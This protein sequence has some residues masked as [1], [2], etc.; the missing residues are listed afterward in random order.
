MPVIL[1]A[2]K[3]YAIVD[4][5]RNIVERSYGNPSDLQ[6]PGTVPSLM[7]VCL[8]IIGGDI[9]AS[10]QELLADKDDDS[11]EE[12]DDEDESDEESD[13]DEDDETSVID[14]C[15]EQIPEHLRR[16]VLPSSGL[17]ESY[18]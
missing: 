16:S 11:D 9:E 13:E 15:Y 1:L 3:I 18:G 10:V 5:F 14:G 17:C 12:S 2:Q 6:R 8:G 4:A 7:E